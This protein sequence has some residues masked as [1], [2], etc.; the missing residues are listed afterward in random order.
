MRMYGF[1]LG[2]TVA[3]Y[4]QRVLR[5]LNLAQRRAQGLARARLQNHARRAVPL[6]EQDPDLDPQ[7]RAGLEAFA[8]LMDLLCR[9]VR[10]EDEP[11]RTLPGPR[12]E[13]ADP[14][15]LAAPGLAQGPLP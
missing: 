3:L 6:V 9:H 4:D 14:P 1:E 13:P 2:K 8:D 10:D 5:S 7:A 11:A 12:D 15:R